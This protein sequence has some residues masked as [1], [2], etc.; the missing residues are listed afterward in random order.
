MFFLYS[1]KVNTIDIVGWIIFCYGVCPAHHRMFIN[2]SSLYPLDAS[3]T[4]R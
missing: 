1:T 4:I 2:T 3:S